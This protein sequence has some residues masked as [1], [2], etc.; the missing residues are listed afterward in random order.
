MEG[1]FLLRHSEPDEEPD[2]VVGRWQ[3]VESQHHEGPRP[4]AVRRHLH[5]LVGRRAAEM[6]PLQVGGLP[7]LQS[8]G[9][10]DLLGKGRVHGWLF[11]RQLSQSEGD[12]PGDIPPV[13]VFLYAEVYH[14]ARNESEESP[15]GSIHPVDARAEHS[16]EVRV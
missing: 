6:G 13:A 15:S 2:H 11:V 14:A 3:P 9:E 7:P 16:T 4:H 8:H 1:R 12:E 5:A 10:Q